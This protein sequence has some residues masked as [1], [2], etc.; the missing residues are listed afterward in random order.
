MGALESMKKMRGLKS[1]TEKPSEDR[2][3]TQ[4]A[5]D[6]KE[7]A[8]EFLAEPERNAPSQQRKGGWSRSGQVP[9]VWEREKKKKKKRRKKKKRDVTDSN[10]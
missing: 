9:H 8:G 3:L 5:N 2:A 7:P 1:R 10:T 6:E 4:D